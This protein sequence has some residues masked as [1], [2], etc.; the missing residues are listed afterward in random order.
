MEYLGFWVTRNGVKPIDK[1]RVNKNM[2]PPTFLEEF[3]KFIGL[4]DYYPDMWSRRSH[5]TNIKVKCQWNG[6]KQK[7]FKQIEQIVSRNILLAYPDINEELK[8]HT[9]ASNFQL[10]VVISKEFKW[11]VLYS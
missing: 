8:T 1:N 9:D 7:V 4:L 6:V 5:L 10:G 2:T 11:I 3:C